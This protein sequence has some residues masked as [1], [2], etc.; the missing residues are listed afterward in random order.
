MVNMLLLFNG[1]IFSPLLPLM[2]PLLSYPKEGSYGLKF[3]MGSQITK[4]LGFN[5]KLQTLCD[6]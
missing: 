5:S 4:K 6:F 3:C 2:R 1:V